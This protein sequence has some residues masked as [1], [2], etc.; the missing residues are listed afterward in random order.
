MHKLSSRDGRT[1]GSASTSATAAPTSP[2]RWTCDALA[3]FAATLP[4][5]VVARDYKYMCSDP[6]QELIK[7]DIRELGLN[8][9]VVAAC[10]PHLHEKTF[11]GARPRAGSTPT[12]SRW[13]TSASTS[14]GCT[15]DKAAAHREGQGPGARRRC[16]GCGTT[17]RWRRGSVPIDPDVLV[18][19]GGIAGI[20]AALTLADAGKHVFLVEREPTIG[21]HMAMFDKTFPT[22]DCAACILTPKMTAVKLAPEHHAVDL[23]R[24]RRRSTATSGNFK[25]K[26]TRKPRYIDEDALRRLPGVHR[27]LR[28]QGTARSPTSSTS[29][30]RKRKPIYIPF[31]QA[32]PQVV[33]DRSRE[34]ASSSS[35]GK[36]KKTCVEACGERNAIDFTSRRR[37]EEID[38]GAI[39][40][41]TGF[42]VF[43]AKRRALL[44]LRHVSRTSTPRWR[45]S[46]C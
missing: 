8:R 29:G 35:R 34:P 24:G 2:A 9:I 15:T 37:I 6:G 30:W 14:P 43:D 18:V 38:V 4:G 39:I 32:V 41:A 23:L 7:Q 44:R 33:G 17:S 19:G 11:R 3:E 16:A 10:S 12:S 36:C 13:S 22:L 42:Q 45:S 31:P 46:G 5:V 25:V 26:V 20:Q 27:G 1:R 28:L 21:G 40:V